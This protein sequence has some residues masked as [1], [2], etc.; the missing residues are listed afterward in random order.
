MEKKVKLKK[1]EKRNDPSPV[2]YDVIKCSPRTSKYESIKN[3]SIPKEKKT[4]FA[5]KLIHSHKY[6]PGVGKYDGHLSLDKIY[7]G[8]GMGKR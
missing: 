7:K 4:S 6:K 5:D 3:Y 2:S 1:W 8:P